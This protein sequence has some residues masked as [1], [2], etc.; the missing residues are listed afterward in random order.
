MGNTTV[1]FLR[2]FIDHMEV[3]HTDR[4]PRTRE[5]TIVYNFIGAFDFE[6]GK[7]KAQNITQKQ[8][9]TV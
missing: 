4:K 1:S 5:I 9:R 2:E 7:E 6:Q 8:E 3:F